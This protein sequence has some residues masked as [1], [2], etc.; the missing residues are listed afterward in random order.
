M[1]NLPFINVNDTPSPAPS[2]DASGYDL[3]QS[4]ERRWGDKRQYVSADQ[5]NCGCPQNAGLLHRSLQIITRRPGAR[6]GRV[7]HVCYDYNVVRVFRDAVDTGVSESSPDPARFVGVIALTPCCIV[8]DF[9]MD[10]H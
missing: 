5:M 1:S 7:R 10:N 4:F 2:R 9:V 6:L 8:T 3:E